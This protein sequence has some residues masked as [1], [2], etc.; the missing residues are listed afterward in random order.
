MISRERLESNVRYYIGH[1]LVHSYAKPVLNLIL[2][3]D[4]CL[5]PKLMLSN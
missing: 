2:C 3:I 5:E 1:I 4:F